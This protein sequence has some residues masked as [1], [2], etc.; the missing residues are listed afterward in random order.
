[1]QEQQKNVFAQ[2]MGEVWKNRFSGTLHVRN[3]AGG[4]PYDAKIAEGWLKSKVSA[5]DDEIQKLVARTM[6][7]MEVSKDDAIAA[8]DNLKGRNGFKR[9]S[10]GLFIDGRC[11]KAA[12]KE[13]ASV[14][15]CAG[16]L[17]P[18]N[19]KK[20]WGLT[21]KGLL[22]FVAEHIQVV[23]ERLYLNTS[24]PTGVLQS[25]PINPIT[26]QTG[27]QN[28]EYVEDADIDFTV[29]SDWD[30]TDRQW[31]AI[32]NTGSYQGFGAQRSQGHGRYTVT[33]W[34]RTK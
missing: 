26:K 10:N 24:E 34:D 15:N 21:N 18:E 13:A 16:N 30:F 27:I 28:T 33:R 9:D 23:E 32:W 29:I 19:G 20:G 6:V 14:A 7:E 31:A 2:Y 8:I 11:L 5:K 12:L 3:I 1:M 17:K 22:G 25:F 4:T